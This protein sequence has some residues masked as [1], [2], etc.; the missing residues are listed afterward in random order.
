MTGR[1]QGKTAIVTAAGQGI[2]RAVAEAYARAVPVQA[3]ALDTAATA[4]T[5]RAVQRSKPIQ[6]ALDPILLRAGGRG[7]DARVEQLLAQWGD[8][9][10]IFNL[11][12]GILPETPVE[13]AK[14]L[15]ELV[16]TLGARK[17]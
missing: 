12:H 11:G 2:G 8:G 4:E 17:A 16:H 9:P 6:G 1:L 7:L 14:A 3:V 10:Y 15:V 13:N 5:G